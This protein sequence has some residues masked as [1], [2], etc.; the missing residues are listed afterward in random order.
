[1]TTKNYKTNIKGT[2]QFDAKF[3]LCGLQNV[4]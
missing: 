1:M 2:M 3:L 4:K